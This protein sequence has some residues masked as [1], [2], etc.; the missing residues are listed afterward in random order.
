MDLL[1]REVIA[2]S[3]EAHIAKI[4]D[5]DSAGYRLSQRLFTSNTF[6]ASIETLLR[7]NIDSTVE[8]KYTAMFATTALIDIV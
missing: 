7:Q 3:L 2:D 4:F 8:Q 1:R 6:M 5:T